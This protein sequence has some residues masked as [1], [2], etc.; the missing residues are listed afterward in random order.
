MIKEFLIKQ[1]GIMIELGILEEVVMTHIH[2]L[3]IEERLP[4]VLEKI[5]NI[6]GKENE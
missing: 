1:L 6:L 3:M 5:E 4:I 2:P